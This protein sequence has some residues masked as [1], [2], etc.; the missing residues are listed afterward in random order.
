MMDGSSACLHPKRG[1]KSRG[2]RQHEY[3]MKSKWLQYNE[4]HP[5]SSDEIDQPI[6]SSCTF[7]R[8][9]G[10]PNIDDVCHGGTV[11]SLAQFCRDRRAAR[12]G[13]LRTIQQ[14][15]LHDDTPTVCSETTSRILSNQLSLRNGESCHNTL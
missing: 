1:S 9:D 3:R 2:L 7:I 13:F 15:F 5:S 8:N 11:E 12:R 10:P 14:S 6:S 4:I